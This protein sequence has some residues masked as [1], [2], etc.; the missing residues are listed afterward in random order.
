MR[1]LYTLVLAASLPLV[2]L[3]LWWRGRREAGYRESIGERFGRYDERFDGKL[4]WIHAVS[5]GEVRAAAPLV[6]RLRDALPDHQV[7][8]TCMTA[9][10]RATIRQVYGESV[11]GV[12]LPYDFPST[13]RRFLEHF[14]PRF[15]VIMETELWP[16]LLAA[17]AAHRVPMLLANARMSERSARGYARWAALTGPGLRSLAAVLAQSEADA[18][19]LREL[20]ARNVEVA[21]NLKFDVAFDQPRFDAGRAWRE[22]VGRP[23]LLLA[24]TREGE[25][26]L[27]LDVLP[28]WDGKLLVV[29][30][31]RHPQRFDEV[32]AL[33]QSRR[34]AGMLPA[35]ADRV[36]LGDTM[37]E[38]FFYYAAC[39]VAIVGGS[40]KPLGGQNLIEALA[41]GAPVV[42]GPHMF[43]FAEVARLG[44][45]AGAVA[46]VA[47]PAAALREALALLA[48]PARRARMSAIGRAL[49][50]THRGA[51]DRH[52]Q[53]CLRLLIS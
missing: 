27:L 28:E 37:G 49:C 12:Y 46:Q 31:P 43:N 26:R 16:N 39:D 48:D 25:E 8:L 44:R 7:L 34:S 38:M 53:A 2:L 47:D 13:M 50:E 52:L 36:H 6:Q 45:E 30:V 20:G 19:R 35:G 11:L 15:G 5:V 3:R 21:G 29:V 40:F 10:G 32:A 22:R 9:A 23:V 17:C 41:C 51:A 18:L 24:S 33:A 14:R 1:A 42:T 4:V